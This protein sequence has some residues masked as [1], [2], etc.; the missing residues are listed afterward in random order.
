MK[1]DSSKVIVI[2]N[3]NK[4]NSVSYYKYE[5]QDGRYHIRFGNDKTYFYSPSNVTIYDKFENINL[6]E[7]NI[8][9]NGKKLYDIK[10]V[11][12]FENRYVN[13]IFSND[14]FK[15]Y[16]Y[17]QL[18]FFKKL[19]NKINDKNVFNYLKEIALCV[20]VRTDDNRALLAEQF[21]KMT[22]I[23]E[24]NI[25]Y[26]Y[27]KNIESKK[28][29]GLGRYIFPFGFNIS[30]RDAV[31]N[32][33]SS[34][35][36]IIEGP[37]GTGKTQTI[38]N[39]IAN[40]IINNKTVAVVSN[41]NSATENVLEK[42]EKTDLNFFAAFLGNKN[43][44]EFF[45]KNQQEKYPNFNNWK[46]NEEKRNNTQLRF[47]A[48]EEDI[49]KINELKNEKAKFKEE[50]NHLKLEFEHFKLNYNEPKNDKYIIK[51]IYKLSSNKINK[52][53]IDLESKDTFSLWY[54]I[55]K[56]LFYGIYNF[57]I[58]KSNKQKVI[59]NLNIEFYEMTINELET[60]INYTEQALNNYDSAKISKEHTN[61]SM[62]L[63]K[64]YLANKYS[65]S[66]REQFTY[67]DFYR[68][69]DEFL[70]EYPVIL[71]TTHS[72][73]TSTNPNHVYDYLII[74]E[75]SQVDIVT[76]ALAISC[77]KNIIIVGDDKQLPNVVS[78][79]EKRE[80]DSI[81]AEF[82]LDEKYKYSKHSFLS[83][84]I[85]VFNTAPR[86]LLKEHYRCH[87]KIIG[88]CNK[89]FYNNQLIILN[90]NQDENPV[91][92]YKTVEGNH[93]RKHYNQRQIDVITEEILKS[94][95]IDINKDN[96]GI[97]TPYNNQ[98]DELNKIINQ[99]NIE[100]DTVHK[101]QGR[102]KDVIIIST[103]DDDNNDFS[104]NA[105]LLNVAV[106][107]AVKK[108]FVVVPASYSND[109]SN[110]SNLI[111]YIEYNNMQIIY[112]KINSIFDYLYKCR[113][114][115][116]KQLLKHKD[117]NKYISEQL[118]EEL[119]EKILKELKLSHISYITNYPLKSLINDPSL[120][121]DDEY[122]FVY[123]TDSHNDFILYNMVT[124]EKLLAIEVDGYAFHENN[125]IQLAR[126]SKKDTILKKYNIPIIRCKT[127]HSQEEAKIQKFILEIEKK[128]VEV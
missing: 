42:L 62:I 16:E 20:S 92:V 106:S 107:R 56:L 63:F 71:S 83:S 3:V 87:P 101:F 41:N 98:K 127:N 118:M 102:E 23:D 14:T 51:S 13:I 116:R 35:V 65:K 122:R 52:L 36:S 91:F 104:E 18:K 34:S 60:N 28:S 19:N 76:G 110:I 61:I 69:T 46:L 33:F 100:I 27:L 50:L 95:Y 8:F 99:K 44:K 68:K 49:L 73:R 96:I 4:T 89:N 37:P 90:D 74:D 67:N 43:N 31:V 86:V 79:E 17:S 55:N 126:D 57:S 39:I 105:N 10:Q 94:Q 121:N 22:D 88:F 103:V 24:N 114:L 112:S 109:K 7:V 30:Q 77:A 53:I 64:N 97:I 66:F 115:E 45:L 81:F 78:L 125:P 120:L 93:S 117:K 12:N 5:P 124:K 113:S 2:G 59:E 32:A 26:Y 58:Y 29:N 108:L 1:C 48:L 72:L 38:L 54:K 84:I 119:I 82:N 128:E 70:A 9:S 15:S 85:E 40:A 25:I 6:D 80:T 11:F 123:E 21:E 75:A 111:K 47:D